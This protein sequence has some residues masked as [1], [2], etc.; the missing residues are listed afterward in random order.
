MRAPRGLPILYRARSLLAKKQ[1]IGNE[2]LVF[3]KT[4]IWG[5]VFKAKFV[6]R[7]EFNNRTFLN[8]Q[9][10]KFT[11]FQAALAILFATDNT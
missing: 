6:E 1:L 11:L 7:N 10:P 2:V 5:N 3:R 8:K 4:L 9:C